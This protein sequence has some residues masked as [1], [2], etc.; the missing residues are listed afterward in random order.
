MSIDITRQVNTKCLEM[1]SFTMTRKYTRYAQAD[2]KVEAM[3]T[4]R[5][6][7]SEE[8]R[9]TYEAVRRAGMSRLARDLDE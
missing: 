7:R 8:Q 9:V 4:L 3:T 5:C 6:R 1:F 2:M